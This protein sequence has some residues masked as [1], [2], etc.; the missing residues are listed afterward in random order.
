MNQIKPETHF[1][2]EYQ[3]ELTRETREEEHSAKV[4]SLVK[5]LMEDHGRDC[6]YPFN[7]PNLGEALAEIGEEEL[8]SLAI[9]LG[10]NYN[11]K[12]ENE[13]LVKLASKK[14]TD[15]VVSYWEKQARAE[16]ERQLKND[17]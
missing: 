1:D 10:A 9:V 5:Y 17:Y 11:L 3:R 15:Y 4:D 13:V 14:V 12:Q 16:A 2:E 7:V 6:Y 8:F